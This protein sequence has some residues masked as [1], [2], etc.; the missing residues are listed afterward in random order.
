FTDRP[1]WLR[2]LGAKEN[3]LAWFLA[4][5]ANVGLRNPQEAV[6]LAWKAVE[7]V[8]LRGDYWTTLGAA[9]YRAGEWKAS[10]SA[11]GKA[12]EM[13]QGGNPFDGLLLAMTHHRLKQ[14]DEAKQWLDK[15]VRWLEQAERGQLTN[16]LL[17]TH[18][19]GNRAA[20]ALLRREAEG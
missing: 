4:T 20:A 13:N 11:L 5:C 16:P 1:A 19:E 2:L 10:L 12:T 6:A 15:A 8:P 14:H 7:R 3:R 18:W 9:H 17:Q